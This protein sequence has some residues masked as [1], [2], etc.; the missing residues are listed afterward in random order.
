MPS[1]TKAGRPSLPIRAIP[2]PMAI[3]PSIPVSAARTTRWAGRLK[4]SRIPSWAR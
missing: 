2:T 3:G 1:I 4:L